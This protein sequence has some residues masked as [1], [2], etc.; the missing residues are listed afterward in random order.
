MV[1]SNRFLYTGKEKRR[2]KVDIFCSV[3][4]VGNNQTVRG[5]FAVNGITA[6]ASE[7]QQVGVGTRVGNIPLGCMPELEEN[8]YLEF[9]I[10]NVLETSNLTVDYMNLNLISVE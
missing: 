8:D 2:F 9:W 1:G 7:Q 10:A 5:R 4:S 6:P 3:T